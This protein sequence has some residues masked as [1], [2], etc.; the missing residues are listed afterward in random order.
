MPDIEN[1]ICN[2]YTSDNDTV[3]DLCDGKYVRVFSFLQH[4]SNEFQII[5]RDDDTTSVPI[6]PV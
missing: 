4:N 6:T 2:P 1:F 5:L 3:K